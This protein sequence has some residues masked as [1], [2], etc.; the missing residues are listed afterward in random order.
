MSDHGPRPRTGYIGRHIFL[1]S[2]A[3]LH[4]PVIFFILPCSPIFSSVPV[5][6]LMCLVH[7]VP[8]LFLAC[9]F[10]FPGRRTRRWRGDGGDGGANARLREVVMLLDHT[11]PC[12]PYH[13]ICFK[14]SFLG[15]LPLHGYVIRAGGPVPI[16]LIPPHLSFYSLSF[17][18]CSSLQPCPALVSSLDSL[19][20]CLL[21]L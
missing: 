13:G 3:H 19:L 2:S 17:L 11:V 1:P 4:L 6:W 9:P 16:F 12:M 15:V 20:L 14:D 21:L 8:H 10:A 5:C 7:P 18:V